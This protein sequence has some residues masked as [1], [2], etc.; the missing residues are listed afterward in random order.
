[1]WPVEGIRGALPENLLVFE[2][3]DFV[4]VDCSQCGS[5]VAR[6][7]ASGAT[8]EEILRAAHNHRCQEPKP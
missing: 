6:F 2:N 7:S 1:M 3:T 5:I 4:E 8:P